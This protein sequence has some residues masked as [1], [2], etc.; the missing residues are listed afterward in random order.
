MWMQY[1]DQNTRFFHK[2][3]SARTINN[4]FIGLQ[5]E[6]G[7]WTEDEEQI[8]GIVVRYFEGLFRSTHV[9]QV[10]FMPREKVQQVSSE[11]NEQLILPLTD[12][13]V[14]DA[15]FS[16]GPEKSTGLDGLNPGFF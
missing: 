2:Y 8:Q 5:D 15:I 6:Q 16:M 1:G 14:K 10:E 13:E 11:Q 12:I 7:I 9:E 4:R 3:A